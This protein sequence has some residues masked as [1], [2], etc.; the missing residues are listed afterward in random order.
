MADKKFDN[1]ANKRGLKRHNLV[2]YLRVFD[3]GSGEVL[4]YLV[5]INAKGLMLVCDNKIEPN[6]CYSMVLRWRNQKGEVQ[7][8]EFEGICRW[9]RPD[10][11]PS[12]FGAG[13]SITSA[14]EAHIHEVEDVIKTLCIPDGEDA[15]PPE[16]FSHL[17]V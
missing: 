7:I 13:F 11:N 1:A 6:A 16:D 10:V 5:D 2:Y 4:G 17:R 14:N 9:C 15:P 3:A 8:A 12:F